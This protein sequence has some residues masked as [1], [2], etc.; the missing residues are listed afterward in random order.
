MISA[1]HNPFGDNGIKL[2]APGGR[3]L[4]DDDRGRA[5]GR[6][7]PARAEGIPGAADRPGGAGVGTRRPRPD[8]GERYARPPRATTS[9]DGP[10]PRRACASSSTAPTAPRRRSRPQVLRRA[11]RRRH[12]DPRRARRRQHQ[13]RL[14]VDPPRGAPAAVVASRAPTS[15]WPS[16]ATPT[17]C[18]PSTPTAASSTATT[19]SPSAPSTCHER[20]LLRRRHRG[21]HRHDQPR[22][23]PGHG[24][25]RASRWSRPPSATATCSRRSSDGGFVA[26][27]RAV[28][29]RHLPRP[30]H[31]RRRRCSPGCSCST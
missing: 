25:A 18:S 2:F 11:R 8:G 16:T 22:L 13:R 7:R 19:S 29:S 27:R 9:L 5:R 6:A 24:R 20:G 4:A 14:R 31:H 3:K 1:S 12:G 10:P 23:P 30:G 28:R 26:R 17:G 15:A 21:R